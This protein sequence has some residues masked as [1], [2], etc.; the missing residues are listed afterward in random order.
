[1]QRFCIVAAPTVPRRSPPFSFPA[2]QFSEPFADILHRHCITAAMVV[3][4]AMGSCCSETRAQQVAAPHVVDNDSAK[5]IS[6]LIAEASHRFGIPAPWI[7]AVIGAESAGNLHAVSPKGAMGL[8]QIMPETWADL[9][10]RYHL[11]ADPYDAHDNIIA[12]SA[13]LR[14]LLDRYGAPGFLAAY[15]AGPARWE[16]HLATSKPLPFETRDFLAKVAPVADGDAMDNA[17]L[18]TPLDHS[19]TAASLFPTHAKD[20][21][22]GNRVTSDLQALHSTNN[23]STRDW[24]DLAAQSNGLFVVLTSAA[25]SQ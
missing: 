25:Q 24:I 13:Y 1:M 15:N 10:H 22:N 5:A 3:A 7:R 11:G 20:S 12:G 21:T 16:A 4:I 18:P 14:E 8:M 2:P 23:R 19:W 9:R 6:A 17:I